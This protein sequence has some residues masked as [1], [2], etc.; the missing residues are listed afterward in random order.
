MPNGWMMA[1][2]VT[3]LGPT[4]AACLTAEGSATVPAVLVSPESGFT[5]GLTGATAAP[6]FGSFVEPELVE[7]ATVSDR[8]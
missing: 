3:V 1:A 2:D 8:A 6:V 7:K 5:V 4:V